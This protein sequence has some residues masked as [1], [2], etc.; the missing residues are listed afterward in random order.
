MNK[1]GGLDFESFTEN[2]QAFVKYCQEQ[3]TDE[4]VYCFTKLD[5][6]WKKEETFKC[7]YCGQLNYRWYFCSTCKKNVEE[8]KRS[9]LDDKKFELKCEKLNISKCKYKSIEPEPERSRTIPK[10]IQR[11]V[12]RRDGGKC[13]ECGSRER[14]E[15]DHIIPFSKGGSNTARNIELRCEKCN[16]RKGDKI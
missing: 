10:N 13:V 6:D 11:E 5:V 2:P 8:G 3:L 16:R 7:D 14:L 12:W 4:C 15:Y 9:L 1:L